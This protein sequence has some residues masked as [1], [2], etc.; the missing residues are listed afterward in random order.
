MQAG[1][2]GGCGAGCLVAHWFLLAL[3]ARLCPPVRSVNQNEKSFRTCW[4]SRD[5]IRPACTLTRITND[6]VDK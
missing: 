6:S 5:S 4:F 2:R 1:I 3:A